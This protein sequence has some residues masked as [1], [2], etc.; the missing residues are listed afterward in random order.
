[1][2]VYRGPASKGLGDDSHEFVDAQDLSKDTA[3]WTDNFSVTVNITKDPVASRQAV[4]RIGLSEADVLALYQGLV[5]GKFK[6]CGDIKEKLSQN[7]N[8][9]AAIK[10]KMMEIRLALLKA[11]SDAEKVADVRGIVLRDH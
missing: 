5:A 6:Q 9:L 3:P 2:H 1:M 4:A 8:E 7:E 11:S 10:R